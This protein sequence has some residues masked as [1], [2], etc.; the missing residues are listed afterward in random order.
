MFAGSSRRRF[1]KAA[2]VACLVPT[3]VRAQALVLDAPNVVVISDRL[4]TAGQPTAAALAGLKAQGMEAVISLGPRGGPDL[5]PQEPAIISG[6]GLEFIP[7]PFPSDGPSE[8]QYAAVADALRRVQGRRTLLHC[9][10]NWQASTF[11]FLYRVLEGKED[12]EVAYQAVAK[13]W[14]PSPPWKQFLVT[15]LRQHGIA[16]EPY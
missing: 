15:Q 3:S 12:P 2:L 11:V 9:Q 16:F 5:V 4:V 8:A 10:V 14:S 6:Q 13:V 7:L 1:C